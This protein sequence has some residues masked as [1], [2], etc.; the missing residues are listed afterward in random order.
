MKKIVVSIIAILLIIQLATLSFAMSVTLNQ[1]EEELIQYN[2]KLEQ[3]DKDKLEAENNLNADNT[4]N[5]SSQSMESLNNQINSFM[6]T[7]VGEKESENNLKTI[8]E[9]TPKLAATPSQGP[10]EEPSPSTSPD[11]DITWTDFSKAVVS[12]SFET[13][14]S[15]T[16]KISNIKKLDNHSYYAY[17]GSGK[18]SISK[19]D[20]EATV[21]FLK[22]ENED[23]LKGTLPNKCM[24]L[25]ETFYY[26]FID[27]SQGEEKILATGQIER[28]ELP[29][30]GSRID[31]YLYVKGSCSIYQHTYSDSSYDRK[32]NYKIGKVNDI[33]IL[34]A[35]KSNETEGFKQ[36]LD[37][38]KKNPAVT[39]GTLSVDE[40][41]Y[42]PIDDVS[43]EEKGYYF[44]YY[45]MDDENGK[46]YPLEDVQIYIESLGTLYH[47]AYGSMQISEDNF[48]DPTLSPEKLPYAGTIAVSGAVLLS[49]IIIYYI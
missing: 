33:N 36:L 49:A 15:I 16:M 40:S 34:K 8:A 30:I 42:N 18:A 32:I 24:A 41:N 19:E 11:S 4:Q 9:P 48:E 37:Y 1:T 23:T 14:S 10:T 7:S 27:Y 13:D 35:F 22:V 46:Y 29:P 31:A 3:E 43:L 38:A 5:V 39:E 44:A 12:F 21:Q 45:S 17:I 20:K 2:K 6:S 26:A 28:P 47:F 25:N